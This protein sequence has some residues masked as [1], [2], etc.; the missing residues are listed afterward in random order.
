MPNMQI[1]PPDPL[2][3]AIAD[4]GRNIQDAMRH[5]EEMQ[6]QNQILEMKKQ[7][8]AA[9]LAQSQMQ[10]QLAQQQLQ[11]NEKMFPMQQALASAQVKNIGSET[12]INKARIPM[13]GAQFE[14]LGA[15]TNRINQTSEGIGLQNQFTKDTIGTRAE[16]TGVELAGAKLQNELAQQGIKSGGLDYD[17]KLDLFSKLLNNDKVASGLGKQVA[18]EM[19][20][21][22]KAAEHIGLFQGQQAIGNAL[23]LLA[24]NKETQA[25]LEQNKAATAHWM[26]EA[27]SAKG[28]VKLQTYELAARNRQFAVAAAG[29]P[30]NAGDPVLQAMPGLHARFGDNFD[31]Q[32]VAAELL[33]SETPED[34]YTA[35]LLINPGKLPQKPVMYK[36]PK[37]GQEIPTGQTEDDT[38]GVQKSAD[39]LS[40]AFKRSQTLQK[41]AEAKSKVITVSTPADLAKLPE[42]TLYVRPG[43]DPKNPRVKGA[44]WN[45]PTTRQSQ[46]LTQPT[47]QTGGLTTQKS[48]TAAGSQANPGPRTKDYRRTLFQTLQQSR[49][50]L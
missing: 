15:E 26:A 49:N 18:L 19:G 10:I 43:E 22:A 9:S 28:Q 44:T 4:V 30:A 32:K 39:A 36:N 29:D 8:S 14:Q 33:N 2:A 11:Q 6:M 17:A 40:A 27:D 12:D 34:H 46:P 41:D 1:L 42:G 48:T 3:L 50:K 24:Q 5:R 37:T 16:M 25:K 38:G 47:A 35:Y 23:N 45:G 21:S 20:S 7:E 31:L 13:M